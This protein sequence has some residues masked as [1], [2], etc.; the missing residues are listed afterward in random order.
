MNCPY[1]NHPCEPFNFSYNFS[2]SRTLLFARSSVRCQCTNCIG[3]P[4]FLDWN[5]VSSKFEEQEAL[6]VSFIVPIYNV[7]YDEW[8]D[9]TSLTFCPN[10]NNTFCAYLNMWFTSR[11]LIIPGNVLGVVRRILDMKAFI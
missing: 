8:T 2:S 11:D 6:Q 5:M 7:N 4:A 1:C 9:F 10:D 3:N